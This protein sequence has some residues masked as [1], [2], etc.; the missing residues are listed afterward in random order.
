MVLLPWPTDGA[1]VFDAFWLQ[2]ME[3]SYDPTVMETPGAEVRIMRSSSV[4]C[5]IFIHAH[6]PEVCDSFGRRT[7][8]SCLSHAQQRAGFCTV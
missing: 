1:P 6:D 8:T 4:A 7:G 5:A 3:E 2:D